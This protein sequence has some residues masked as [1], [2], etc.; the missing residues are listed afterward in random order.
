[1]ASNADWFSIR[2]LQ[3]LDIF[4]V[5]DGVASLTFYLSFAG[6]LRMRICPKLEKLQKTIHVHD[7]KLEQ[8]PIVA[9]DF[10]Q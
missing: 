2:F 8:F 1:M 9:Y 6:F 5:Q 7:A 10:H 4:Q 3:S